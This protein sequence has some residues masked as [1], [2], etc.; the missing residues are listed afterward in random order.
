MPPA[1]QPATVVLS[2]A[3]FTSTN[4]VLQQGQTGLEQDTGKFKVGDGV[5]HWVSLAYE[6][7]GQ[8]SGQTIDGGAP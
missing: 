2:A 4:P 3:T 7:P 1:Q 8:L 5:T 6:Y